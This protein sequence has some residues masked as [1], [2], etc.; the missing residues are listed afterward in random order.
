MK[1]EGAMLYLVKQLLFDLNIKV[2]RDSLESNFYRLGFIAPVACIV[3]FF[4]IVLFYA[5]VKT[6]STNE[7]LWRD[8]IIRIHFVVLAVFS[9]VICVLLFDKKKCRLSLVKK[10]ILQYAIISIVLLVSIGLTVYDQLVTQSIAPYIIISLA[11]AMSFLIK[12]L[13]AL[14]LFSVNYVVFYWVIGLVQKNQAVLVSTRVN[15]LSVNVLSLL[16]V[17][18]LWASYSVNLNQRKLIESQNNELQNSKF[19]LE[20]MNDE[21]ELA[22]YQTQIKPHFFYNTLNTISYICLQDGQQASVLVEKLAVFLRRHFDF[23]EF[24]GKVT[25]FDE[26][27]LIK[28]YTDIQKAR[29]LDRLTLKIEIE[30]HLTSLLVP[31]LILQPLIENAIEHGILKRITGGKIILRVY[32]LHDWVRFEVI[33]NGIGMSKEA[34]DKVFSSNHSIYKSDQTPL[35]KG[36]GLIN[37]QKRLK[38]Y[39]GSELEIIKNEFEGLTVAFVIHKQE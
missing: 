38:K 8:S 39:Y 35:R 14:G 29:F 32:E 21:L 9:L 11:V 33:D 31:S 22:F 5:F 17:C 6:T 19:F 15:A 28:T 13:I 25:L 1:V 7:I 18:I 20:R 16:L 27:E 34:I 24:N 36:I 2:E 37:I 23:Y 4:H 12:P 10:N 3:S 26:V 30:N